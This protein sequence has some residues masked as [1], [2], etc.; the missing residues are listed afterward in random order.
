VK[1]SL[2]RE[3]KYLLLFLS[4]SFSVY[5]F[6]SFIG[7]ENFKYRLIS[8][9]SNIEILFP[10]DLNNASYAE[11]IQIPGIGPSYAQRI[12]EYRYNNKGFRSIEELMN[13]KGIGQKSL[14]KIRPY[15]RL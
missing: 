6:L 13:I 8:E 11:L 1:L 12:I 10:L 15:I 5:L 14:D 2:N 3:L 7:V 4:L 9:R